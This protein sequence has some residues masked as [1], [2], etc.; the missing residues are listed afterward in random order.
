MCEYLLNVDMELYGPYHS[1]EQVKFAQNLFVM[2]HPEMAGGCLIV[3]LDSIL[4]HA[5][6]F[7]PCLLH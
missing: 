2:K 5:P 6:I 3:P 4:Q 7:E 1:E